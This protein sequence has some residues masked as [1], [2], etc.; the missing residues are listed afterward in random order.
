M[1]TLSET[2]V[3][4][5]EPFADKPA[6]RRMSSNVVFLGDATGSAVVAAQMH[7]ANA[8]AQGRRSTFP[9]TSA[10]SRDGEDIVRK[11][12]K[13]RLEDATILQ[14]RRRRNTS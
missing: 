14:R 8:A 11:I 1:A 3:E 13:L 5:A 9:P 10:G 6:A 12:G 7:A 4:S 2:H